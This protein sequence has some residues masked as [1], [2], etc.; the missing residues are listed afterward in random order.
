MRD[1]KGEFVQLLERGDCI[2]PRLNKVSL[3]G[4]TGSDPEFHTF[5]NGGRCVT[6][7]VATDDSYRDSQSGEL[8]KR[9]EWHRVVLFG[10]KL[11]E[12]V[13]KLHRDNPLKG[14]Q[15]YIEGKLRTR[16]WEDQNKVKR[17]TT[18]VV[19][20]G[21]EGFQLLGKKA[22]GSDNTVSSV[23]SEAPPPDGQDIPF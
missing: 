3:I 2:M 7:S 14:S 18:E 12:V 15:I 23:P 16:A 5:Q 9:T 4:H 8:V 6:L 22:N 19:V 10:Q 1:W 21:W 13:E 11:V 20:V 17:Y